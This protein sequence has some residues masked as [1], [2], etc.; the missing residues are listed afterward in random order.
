MKFSSFSVTVP[1]STAECLTAYR[2]FIPLVVFAYNLH[3]SGHLHL[4]SFSK[5][6]LSVVSRAG[7]GYHMLLFTVTEGEIAVDA[8]SCCKCE[9]R[10]RNFE[11]CFK[12]VTFE[13]TM[14]CRGHMNSIYD[15][16]I[17]HFILF[18]VS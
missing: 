6:W 5:S 3:G 12:L 15:Q 18:V 7:Q 11:D 14:L 13:F 10:Y 1:C 2:C 9:I 16:A 17:L 4:F 8:D